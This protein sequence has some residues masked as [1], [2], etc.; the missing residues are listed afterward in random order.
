MSPIRE[1]NREI[2]EVAWCGLGA[3]APRSPSSQP[4]TARVGRDELG[5]L[6]HVT[7]NRGAERLCIRSTGDVDGGVERDQ[8]KAVAVGAFIRRLGPVVARVIERVRALERFRLRPPGVAS[9]N[10]R[11]PNRA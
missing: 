3:G 5:L 1:P 4:G 8:S 10:A 11:S 9:P 6:D 7:K 2:R